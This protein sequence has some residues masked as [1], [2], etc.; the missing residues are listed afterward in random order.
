MHILLLEPKRSFLLLG[1][2]LITHLAAFCVL[3]ACVLPHALGIALYG[4]CFFSLWQQLS[5]LFSS[6]RIKKI[7]WEKQQGWYLMTVEH[8]LMSA[9]LMSGS[10]VTRALVILTFKLQSMKCRSIVLFPDALDAHTFRQL[11]VFLLTQRR[12][13]Q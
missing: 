10:Y 3:F 9:K 4:V 1:F 8:K 11:R 7:H 13:L 12:D 2:I 5:A 6:Q